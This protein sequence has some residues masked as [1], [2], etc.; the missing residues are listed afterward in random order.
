MLCCG[1]QVR[2]RS[3][4]DPGAS[5]VVVA[6]H[7]GPLLSVTGA[8]DVEWRGTGFAHSTWSQPA[9]PSGFVER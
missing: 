3:A 1:S 4:R 8:A 7:D 5:R 2:V 9:A 6:A